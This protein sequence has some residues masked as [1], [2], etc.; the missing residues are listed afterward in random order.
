MLVDGTLSISRN[1]LINNAV[2]DSVGS[3]MATIDLFLILLCVSSLGKG[4]LLKLIV[5][6][7]GTLL[8]QWFT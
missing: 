4:R 5:V 6:D 3:I 8:R 1:P 7:S 2:A